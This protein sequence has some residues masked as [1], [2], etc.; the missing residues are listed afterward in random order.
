MLASVCSAAYAPLAVRAQSSPPPR[1]ALQPSA[2]G[3]VGVVTSVPLQADSAP[4]ERARVVANVLAHNTWYGSTGGLRVVDAGS[5]PAG[6]LRFQLGLDYFRSRGFL[7]EDDVHRQL[8]G[9]LSVSGTPLPFLELFGSFNARSN[10][11]SAGNPVLLQAIGDL[12]FGGKLYRELTPWLSLGGDLRVLLKNLL[13]DV[14][15][16]AGATSVGL[17]AAVTADFSALSR[18]FPVLLRANLGYMLN[19]S[20]ELVQ[21]VEDQRYAGLPEDSRAPKREETRNLITRIE[22][23]GLGVDRVDTLELALGAELPLRLFSSFE[24]RPLLEWQ[25]GV[26]VNRQGLDCPAGSS[27]GRVDRSDG[28]LSH[29]G[30]TAWPSS[31]SVGARVLPAVNGLALLAALELGVSG[32]HRFVHELAPTRPWAVLFALSYAFSPQPATQVRY[33]TVPT[34]QA[35]AEG[36]TAQIAAVRIRGQVV[37]GSTGQPIIGAV[38]HYQEQE[39][40]PQLTG[41]EGRYTS[42]AFPLGTTVPMEIT[43][44]DYDP[45]HCV[46]KIPVA[47]SAVEPAQAERFAASRCEL[48]P[49]PAPPLPTGSR[50]A[51]QKR[52]RR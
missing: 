45:A 47:W 52:R 4:S 50:P 5:G 19:N 7:I 42:Y 35:D 3:E 38:V 1:S 8:G 16:N 2:A 33:V 44:P 22:R 49:L 26:P 41:S 30:L 39:L 18:A 10:R 12:Q 15:L 40:S 21:R 32:A 25:V 48:T 29:V 17:R 34:P 31:L 46:V 14:G 13:G 11:N 6:T 9:T 51:L 23:F 43:H 20:G 37:D 36:S 24:V 27:S 28:C